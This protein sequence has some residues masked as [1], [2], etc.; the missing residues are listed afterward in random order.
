MVERSSND[1]S[2]RTQVRVESLSKQGTDR[3]YASCTAGERIGMMWQLTIDAWAFL[4]ES[5]NESRFQRHVV[6]VIRGKR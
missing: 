6:N 4:G 5:V 2:N 3:D 1:Q